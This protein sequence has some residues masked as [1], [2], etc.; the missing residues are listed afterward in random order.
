MDPNS[1]AFDLAIHLPAR[2]SRQ[3]G[4]DLHGQLRAAIIGGRLQPGLRLPASRVMAAALG[5][6]RNTVVAAYDLLLSEGYVSAHGRG[7]DFAIRT[8]DLVNVAGR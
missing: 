4:R 1:S 7:K 3:M 8:F 6:S 5:V 2:N